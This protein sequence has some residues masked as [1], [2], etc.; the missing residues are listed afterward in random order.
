MNKINKA[1][2]SGKI[3][4]ISLPTTSI[5]SK[6]PAH[7]VPKTAEEMAEIRRQCEKSANLNVAGTCP[8]VGKI[9]GVGKRFKR[10]TLETYISCSVDQYDA[11]HTLQLWVEGVVNG[12]EANLVLAGPHGVG[13]TH[14]AVSLMKIMSQKGLSSEIISLH[15]VMIEIRSSYRSHVVETERSILH[16]LSHIDLLVLDDINQ[17]S[18]S[19]S[20]RACLQTLLDKRYRN[21]KPTALIT[22][23]PSIKFRNSLGDGIVSRLHQGGWRWIAC[24][25]PAFSQPH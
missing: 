8:L 2:V 1:S 5:W 24:T 7:I 18:Y 14:L 12:R 22:P 11:L 4:R 10:S 16:R 21:R 15:E 20:E 23:L 3:T 6:V 19:R 9:T 17:V 13:K 25:W